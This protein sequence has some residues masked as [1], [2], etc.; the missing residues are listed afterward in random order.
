MGGSPGLVVMGE[1]SWSKGCEFEYRHWMDT[2]HI[3]VCCKICNVCFKRQ[4]INDKETGLAHLKKLL[5]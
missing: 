3:P 5:N 1:D 2:F 4:K